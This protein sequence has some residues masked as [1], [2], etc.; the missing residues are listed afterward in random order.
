[1]DNERGLILFTAF[2]NHAVIRC[3]ICVHTLVEQFE[4]EASAP[5]RSFIRHRRQIEKLVE[6]LIT[7][8]RF[9]DDGSIAIGSA[10]CAWLHDTSHRPI[11]SLQPSALPA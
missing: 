8:E 7:E 3:S 9:E 4:G 6:E 11:S 10:D 1:L 5:L 2:S